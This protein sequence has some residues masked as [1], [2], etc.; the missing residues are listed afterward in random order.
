MA[1]TALFER[2]AASV[3]VRKT[4]VYTLKTCLIQEG[5]PLQKNTKSAWGYLPDFLNSCL[6]WARQHTLKSMIT[7]NTCWMSGK[8]VTRRKLEKAQDDL[9]ESTELHRSQ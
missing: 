3:T 8:L 6:T 1:T 4:D 2:C 7:W 9:M 5:V